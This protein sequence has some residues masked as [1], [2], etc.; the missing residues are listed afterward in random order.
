MESP[1]NNW[2]FTHSPTIL[3]I[4]CYKELLV[5]GRIA[6]E[7]WAS[8]VE[9]S[10]SFAIPALAVLLIVGL[11]PFLLRPEK[12]VTGFLN[13]KNEYSLTLGSGRVSP[14]AYSQNW[15][16]EIIHSTNQFFVENRGVSKPKEALFFNVRAV[17]Y[18]F[19]EWLFWEPLNKA[20]LSHREVWLKPT[21]FYSG[22]LSVKS[23]SKRSPIE[24]SKYLQ[25][26]SRTSNSTL[27]AVS[28]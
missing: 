20:Y 7:A 9:S 2:A 13:R 17:F 22:L 6:Q 27:T 21:R 28:W 5:R 16:T 1:H 24:Q 3:H 18:W 8:F 25:S 4:F 14:R 10:V 26:S 15:N 19:S 11:R 12:A 23:T